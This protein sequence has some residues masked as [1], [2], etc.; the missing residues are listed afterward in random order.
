MIDSNKSWLNK[1]LLD[2]RYLKRHLNLYGD[3]PYPHKV[4]D[5][6]IPTIPE[7]QKLITDQ[8]Q[9]FWDN[10]KSGMEEQAKK[11]LDKIQSIKPFPGSSVHVAKA[12]I[13]PKTQL[14]LSAF[15]CHLCSKSYEKKATMEKHI[16]GKLFSDYNKVAPPNIPD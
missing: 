13:L 5:S 7:G 16:A 2:F 9:E 4:H 1:I 6:L 11:R 14:G 15:P 12:V 3:K 8:D 10:L